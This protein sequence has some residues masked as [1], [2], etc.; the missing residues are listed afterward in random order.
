MVHHDDVNRMLQSFF[1]TV[2]CW[3]A[4]LLPFV[5]V[6]SH[7]MTVPQPE[8]SFSVRVYLNPNTGRFW[9]MDSYEGDNGDP[10]SLHKYLFVADNPVN[11]V[12]PSGHL[13]LF[14]FNRE[15]GNWAHRV[16]EDEYQAEHPGAICGTTTGILGTRLKPDIFD[17]IQR[18]FMEIKPL[19]LSGVAKGV[20]QI[21]GYDLAFSALGL[22]YARGTT[23]PAGARQSNVGSTPI[24]Y[25]NVQGVI[26]YTDMVDN[27]DDIAGISSFVLARQFILSNSALMTRTLVG[28][29]ARIPGLVAAGKSADTGRL[30]GMMGIASILTAMGF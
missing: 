20:V 21:A 4:L 26:F 8:R 18:I 14:K 12:D 29:M 28:S 15:F 19:S 7:S 10:S 17:G 22:D 6:Q 1:C 16:I 13:G 9:T 11:G 27:L 3:I 25:F 24:V 5:P 2:A 23:W 30:G